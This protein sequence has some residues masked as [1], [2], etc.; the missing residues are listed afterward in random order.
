MSGKKPQ[1]RATQRWVVFNPSLLFVCVHVCGV[2]IDMLCSTLKGQLL[3]ACSLFSPS[4]FQGLTS[5]S[6]GSVASTLTC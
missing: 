5:G 3:R 2:S 1:G 4:G 6:Q